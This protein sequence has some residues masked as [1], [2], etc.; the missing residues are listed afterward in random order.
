MFDISFCILS[1][2][3]NVLSIIFYESLHNFDFLK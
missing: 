3:A 1:A 2:I